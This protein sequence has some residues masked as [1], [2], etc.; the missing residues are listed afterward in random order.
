MTVTDRNATGP[1]AASASG[2]FNAIDVARFVLAILIIAIHAAP[3][4]EINPMANFIVMEIFARTAVPFFFITASY[5]FFRKINISQLRN[6]ADAAGAERLKHYIARLIKIYLIWSLIYIIP[7]VL[8]CVEIHCGFAWTAFRLIRGFFLGG[9]YLHF[10]YLVVL[11][12][13]IVAV[14]AALRHMKLWFLLVSAAALYVVA[15]FLSSYSIFIRNDFWADMIVWNGYANE[16]LY[17]L[18]FGLMFVVLGAVLSQR[19]TLNF[20]GT[21]VGLLFLV[22]LGAMFFEAFFLRAAGREV[23]FDIT[24]A[25]VPASVFLFLL[26]AN[27]NMKDRP[28]IPYF[29]NAS[30]L[31]YLV[32]PFFIY[33]YSRIDPANLHVFLAATIGSVLFSVSVVALQRTKRLRF[34]SWLC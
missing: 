16:M 28:L 12:F 6:R 22:S 30:L 3:L 10:W 17:R 25:L 8:E 34:L 18:P 13:S 33:I 29:R 15:L 32:H 27:I 19:R 4:L 7:V 23:K 5:F 9:I 31:I 2:N 1:L 24:I 14:H 21:A 11:M 26:L 20:H